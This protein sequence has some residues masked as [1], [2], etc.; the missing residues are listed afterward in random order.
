MN[1][2]YGYATHVGPLAF[3]ISDSEGYVFEVGAG[4]VST[5][6][7]HTMLM[8]TEPQREIISFENNDRWFGPLARDFRCPWHEFVHYVDL[9]RVFDL[10]KGPEKGPESAGVIL[11]DND[12]P[13]KTLEEVHG[14]RLAVV[15]EALKW[16]KYVVVHDT[17][18]KSVRE[19]LERFE[20]FSV[21]HLSFKTN[22]ETTIFSK[23]VDPL[24]RF[25]AWIGV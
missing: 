14:A 15:Q 22:P 17:E 10:F 12:L 13:G 7:I 8:N 19:G 1:N 5:P 24:E 18:E 3:A 2:V 21:P 9:S 16:A 6:I 20:L 11:V 23:K 4:M 25:K